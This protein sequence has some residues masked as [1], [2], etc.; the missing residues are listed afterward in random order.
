MAKVLNKYIFI[1]CTPQ[2]IS[3][4]IKLHLNFQIPFLL[5][6]LMVFYAKHKIDLN[7]LLK[8][9]L[10]IQAVHVKITKTAK[11]AKYTGKLGHH[12]LFF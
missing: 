7:H 2:N 4:Q 11:R 9:P 5:N 10:L 8:L 1:N 3:E 12:Q 6:F